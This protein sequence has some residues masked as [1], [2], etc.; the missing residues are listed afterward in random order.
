MTKSSKGKLVRTG[1]G[2]ASLSIL[3]VTALAAADAPV[4]GP[5]VGARVPP[6]EAVDHTGAKQGLRGLSGEHGLL[7]LF[8]RSADW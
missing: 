2:A 6:F 7:L 3:A 8:F 4:A 5:A 1:R